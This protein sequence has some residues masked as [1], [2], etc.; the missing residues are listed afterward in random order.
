MLLTRLQIVDKLRHSAKVIKH[1]SP[2]DQLLAR[3]A[4]AVA[5]RNTFLFG[6]GGALVVFVTSLFVSLSY[7]FTGTSANPSDPRR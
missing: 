1:L 2:A 7:Y 6:L 4:Y 3:Q 5:L